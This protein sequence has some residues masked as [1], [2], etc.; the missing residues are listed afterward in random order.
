V[1]SIENKLKTTD[2]KLKSLKI[3]IENTP[4]NTDELV[5][6]FHNLKTSLLSI[7]RKVFGNESKTEIGEKNLPTL[8]NRIR[9][10]SQGLS[11]YYG[12]TKLHLESLNMARLMNEDIEPLIKEFINKKINSLENKIKAIGGPAI[13]DN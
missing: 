6:D 4:I 7:K 5:L 10:A 9:V 3:A 8:F 1:E 12:P 11:S 13:I 2:E